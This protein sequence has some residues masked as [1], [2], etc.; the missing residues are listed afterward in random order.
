MNYEEKY[1]EALE[2]MR[3]I[4]PNLKGDAKL[5]VEHAFPELAE[6][7]DERIRK[8]LIKYHKQ[9]FEN[10]RDQEVG[11]FHKDALAY[12]EKQKDIEDRWIEDRGQCFWNGVEEGK[13]LAEKQEEQKPE[14]SEEDEEMRNAL[15][16]LLHLHYAQDNAQTL[17]GIEA[18]KFRSWLK[19]L[20]PSWKPSEEQMAMLL[21][22]I[23]EPNNAGAES[24]HLALK[25]IYEQ[26][27]K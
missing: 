20:R 17:V 15:W 22:V 26:L 18:G 9:Q 21:A 23:N 7:E 25:S 10:N 16:N 4:Y 11:L 13:M 5:A 2:D 12:L 14:W 1:K 24:C 8:E 27:K 3:V 6:S 19:S